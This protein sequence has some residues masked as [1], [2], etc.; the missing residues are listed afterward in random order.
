MTDYPFFSII[1][2]T[3]KLTPYLFPSIES[4]LNQTYQQYELIIV[5]NTPENDV[6]DALQSFATKNQG[7]MR[8]V[9]TKI[10]QLCFNLNYGVNLANGEYIVRMDSDDISYP[11]RLSCLYDVCKKQ[12][13]D[14]VG[15][16]SDIID[17]ND[18]IRGLLKSPTSNTQIRR[19]MLYKN[20][21]I[22]PT[23]AIKKSTLLKA[24]GYLGGFFSEDYD[25]WLRLRR[26]K[27]VIFMNIPQ[28]LFKYRVHANQSRGLKLSYAEST[29]LIYREWLLSQGLHTLFGYLFTSAKYWIFKII[30]RMR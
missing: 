13:P 29:A 18:N 7:Q 19:T 2:C 25:L 5:V 6:W 21:F 8:I 27:E 30:K 20:P 12:Q 11:E 23:V 22:H 15:S 3:H 1:L 28:I 17:E 26:N 14:V 9:R 4:I 10:H 24:G 16:W